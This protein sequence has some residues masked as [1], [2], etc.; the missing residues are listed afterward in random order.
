VLKGVEKQYSDG[1]P[2]TSEQDLY[3][4]SV[5]GEKPFGLN[6]RPI[7]DGVGK[8]DPRK[9]TMLPESDDALAEIAKIEKASL[10]QGV[11]THEQGVE[12]P[13]EGFNDPANLKV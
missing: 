2:T 7:K 3:D 11:F 5:K 6:V 13:W 10:S 1:V 8:S 12:I 9:G 4:L